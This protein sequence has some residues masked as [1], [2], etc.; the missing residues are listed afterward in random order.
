MRTEELETLKTEIIGVIKAETGAKVTGYYLETKT[1]RFEVR[2]QGPSYFH[3]GVRVVGHVS[4]SGLYA[5]GNWRDPWFATTKLETVKAKLA[6]LL[7]DLDTQEKE[8][9]AANDSA[10]KRERRIETE[11]GAM[12]TLLHNAGFT[13]KTPYANRIELKLSVGELSLDNSKGYWDV[14]F[15][16]CS[17]MH[18]PAGILALAKLLDGRPRKPLGIQEAG[19]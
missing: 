19:L 17:A 5:R 7:A 12:L 14:N 6:K 13:A 4:V 10:A 2:F 11:T 15:S 8:M 1:R 16:I 3:T 9:R 18:N